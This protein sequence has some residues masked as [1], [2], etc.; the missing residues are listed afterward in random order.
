MIKIDLNKAIPCRAMGIKL[1]PIT[2]KV[3]NKERRLY[4]KASKLVEEGMTQSNA[5]ALVNNH[6]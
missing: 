3:L 1:D 2:Q 5:E 6:N 4:K